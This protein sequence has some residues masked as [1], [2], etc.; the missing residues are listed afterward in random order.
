MQY[1]DPDFE[2]GANVPSLNRARENYAEFGACERR[3]LEYVRAPTDE[4]R[5]AT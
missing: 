2:E 5:R 1:E 3:L 4:E